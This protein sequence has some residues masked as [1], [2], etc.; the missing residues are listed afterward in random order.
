MIFNI[1]LYYLLNLINNKPIN[2]DTRNEETD[3]IN[4]K[5]KYPSKPIRINPIHNKLTNIIPKMHNK[6]NLKLEYFECDFSSDVAIIMLLLI[7]N[8]NK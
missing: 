1:F 3:N 7:K 6:V 2:N 5:L 4:P 8:T